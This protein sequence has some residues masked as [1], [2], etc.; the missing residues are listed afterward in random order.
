[1]Q[2]TI[3]PEVEALLKQ[4]LQSGRFREPNDVIATALLMLRDSTPQNLPDPTKRSLL[5]AARG[6]ILFAD[7][8]D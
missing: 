4:E 7:D 5:N 1:M 8:W 6:Q 2:L 3:T